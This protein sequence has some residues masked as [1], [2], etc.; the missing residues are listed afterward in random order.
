MRMTLFL[1]L[2]LAG[3]ACAYRAIAARR[4]LSSTIYLASVSAVAATLLYLLGTLQLAVI[5]LSV[6]AGLVTVLLVWAISMTGNDTLDTRPM[7]PR[8]LA[9]AAVLLAAVLL[10]GMAASLLARDIIAEAAPLSHMLWAA[11]RLDVWVQIILIFAG[12]LGVLGLLAEAKRPAKAAL[13]A[14]AMIERAPME[15]PPLAASP[16]TGD[17][18]QG[19]L[20]GKEVRP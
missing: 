8:S 18:A 4:I 16:L 9:V 20:A 13:P 17:E 1:G 10:F 7:L 3:I 2:A 19:Q 5:E 11:R 15:M 6:G 12:V 14:A